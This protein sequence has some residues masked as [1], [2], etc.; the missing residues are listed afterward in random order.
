[1]APIR[2][3]ERELINGNQLGEQMGWYFGWA[4]FGGLVSGAFCVTVSGYGIAFLT[5]QI[6]NCN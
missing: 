4:D 2:F 5:N 3:V 1:M 6:L